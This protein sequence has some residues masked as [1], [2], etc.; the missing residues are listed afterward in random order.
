MRELINLQDYPLDRPGSPDWVTLVDNCKAKLAEDGLFNLAGFINADA[1][2]EAVAELKPVLETQSFTHS[3]KHNIYFQKEIEGLPA[4]H[5]ALTEYETSN[6]TICADQ[7]GQA[8]VIR[9]YEWPPFAKFL[10]SVMDKSVLFTMQDP[11]ARVNVMGYHEGQALNW[12]F[13]RSEF[14]TT[15]LLQ[16]PEVGGEF[17]YDQD[18]RSADDPNYAG[19]A[20]LL[21]G[22]RSPKRIVL[23]PGTLNIFKGKNTAHRVTPVKGDQDRIIAV[24]SF[25]ERPGVEFSEQE[26]IGFYGRA[27]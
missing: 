5:P 13:D 19:V 1:L 17:E 12:H 14:T 16:A 4:D 23:E 22:H 3:R 8:A 18:L 10:A 24:F 25:Y 11:L 6:R 7:M 27:A 15:L 21:E 2:P 9:L 20:D 26:R